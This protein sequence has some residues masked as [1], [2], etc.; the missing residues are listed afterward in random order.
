MPTPS[1]YQQYRKQLLDSALRTIHERRADSF[2]CSICEEPIEWNLLEDELISM[3][4]EIDFFGNG[5]P[6]ERQQMVLDGTLCPDC[7][8][9]EADDL[10]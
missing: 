7:Y 9:I 3:M 4:E 6:N 5:V 8:S 2:V 10:L 1:D